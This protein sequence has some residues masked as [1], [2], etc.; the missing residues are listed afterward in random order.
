MLTPHKEVILKQIDN[1]I[2]KTLI[3]QGEKIL[4]KNTM[5][6]VQLQTYRSKIKHDKSKY[7]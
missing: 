6:I 1:T 5:K 4:E 2:G 3:I 7:R